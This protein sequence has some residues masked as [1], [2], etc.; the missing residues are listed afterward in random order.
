MSYLF[1]HVL[2]AVISSIFDKENLEVEQLKV[3]SVI[4]SCLIPTITILK[5][6]LIHSFIFA[7]AI[8][9]QQH[10]HKFIVA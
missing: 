4:N 5:R 8:R 1:H 7:I 9:S 2:T 10:P 3:I 6:V